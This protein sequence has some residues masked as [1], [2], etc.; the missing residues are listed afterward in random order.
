MSKRTRTNGSRATERRLAEGRGQGRGA[1]Y[2]PWI[3]I[4]DLASRGQANRVKSPLHGRTCHLHSQLES[5]WF[6]SLHA[7]AG[8]KDLREQYPFLELDERR[9]S[10]RRKSGC[11]CS[12]MRCIS[13]SPSGPPRPGKPHLACPAGRIGRTRPHCR[14]ALARN[15]FPGRRHQ[16]G[17]HAD[18]QL[19]QTDSPSSAFPGSAR[20][21]VS[22]ES[23]SS[24]RLHWRVCTFTIPA[25][26]SF[27]VSFS[28]MP[29]E[30][31]SATREATL[32]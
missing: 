1:D 22:N 24:A 10:F 21:Q 30:E 13:L 2:K 12:W 5:D 31:S 4:H 25:A 15:Q 14:R 28:S 8:L 6:F 32:G 3:Q 7:L 18:A 9:T 20:R 11:T 16:S 29:V 23:Y 17:Q 27:S 19:E 26:A